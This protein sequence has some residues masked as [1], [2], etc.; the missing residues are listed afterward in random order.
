MDGVWGVFILILVWN[1][2]YKLKSRVA[3]QFYLQ[4]CSIM[5]HVLVSADSS[6]SMDHR[7]PSIIAMRR[8]KSRDPGEIG[9]K[10]NLR[11]YDH[12]PDSRDSIHTDEHMIV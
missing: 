6:S 5:P 11:V 8:L 4:K 1:I 10:D 9:L 2:R 12:V 3:T 7:F